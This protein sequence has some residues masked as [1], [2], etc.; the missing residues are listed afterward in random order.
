MRGRLGDIGPAD[1]KL[2]GEQGEHDQPLQARGHALLVPRTHTERESGLAPGLESFLASSASTGPS[3]MAAEGLV[4]KQGTCRSAGSVHA[5]GNAAARRSR[6]QHRGCCCLCFLP[7]DQ[8]GVMCWLQVDQAA[9][10]GESLPVKKVP[11]DVAFSG[12]AIKQAGRA[13]PAPPAGFF[14]G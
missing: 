3:P 6:M 2:A 5:R 1:V 9:L 7:A 8:W 13:A 12:S 10:T 11:G 4:L 14:G